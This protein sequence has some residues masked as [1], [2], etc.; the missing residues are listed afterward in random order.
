MGSASEK[1][2]KLR[3]IDREK[4]RKK[5]RMKETARNKTERGRDTNTTIKC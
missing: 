1:I 5:E 3:P 4:E 2:L